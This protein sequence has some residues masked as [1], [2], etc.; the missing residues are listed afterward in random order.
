MR[1]RIASNNSTVI[2]AHR[3]NSCGYYQLCHMFTPATLQY[4]QLSLCISQPRSLRLVITNFNATV[5]TFV[6]S[7]DK[8]RWDNVADKSTC[9]RHHSCTTALRN[10]AVQ[11]LFFI[12]IKCEISQLA[13]LRH[14]SVPV[15]EFQ[16]LLPPN[17]RFT[18]NT[19]SD[20]R[21]CSIGT[22]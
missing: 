18:V 10:S 2:L 3:C 20:V 16:K 5:F 7:S 17:R 6:T 22:S 13:T 21:D 4:S 9:A 15:P 1:I 12:T 11:V 8:S 19:N 14:M